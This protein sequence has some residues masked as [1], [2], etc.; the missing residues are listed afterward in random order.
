MFWVT[1][2]LQHS[3]WEIPA[4]SSSCETHENAAPVFRPTAQQVVI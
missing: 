3:G 2:F 1:Y 4:L